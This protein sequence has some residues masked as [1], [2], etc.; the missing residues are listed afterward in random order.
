MSSIPP[1]FIPKNPTGSGSSQQAG[2][3]QPYLS[4]RGVG[5]RL[6]PALLNPIMDFINEQFD[7][8]NNPPTTFKKRLLWAFHAGAFVFGSIFLEKELAELLPWNHHA[9]QPPT[10]QPPMM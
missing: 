2:R 8:L 6:P 9:Q 5:F 1:P 3:F 10:Q 7:A 4:N